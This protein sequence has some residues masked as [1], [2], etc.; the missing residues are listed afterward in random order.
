MNEDKATRYHRLKRRSSVAGV[1]SG[2]AA[3]AAFWLSGG[4]AWLR[5]AAETAVHALS[6]PGGVERSAVVGV[7]VLALCVGAELLAF[8]LAAYRG[9]VL[10]RR[11]GLSPQPFARWCAD[12]VKASLLGTVLAVAAALVGYA[13][14]DRSPR[15]W[16]AFTA[17]VFSAASV[18]IA[19]AAPVLLFPLFF[20]FRPLE[21]EQLV[22]RLIRLASKVGAPVLG[23]YEWSLG[24]RSRT[25]NAALVGIGGTRRILVSDTLLAAYSDDE[26]EVI[27]AH[28]LA[29][30]V[31]GDLWKALAVDAAL[32]LGALGFVHVMLQ[33]VP[34][35]GGV[36]GAA[37]VAGLPVVLLAAAA[38]SMV[39]LPAVNGLSRAHERQADRFAL[40]LTRNP[41]AFISAMKRLGAQNLAD[42]EPSPLVEWL[43]HSHPPLPR[44]L[45]AARA[46]QASAFHVSAR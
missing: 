28:E 36:R 9:F 11:Y 21:R 23:V 45:A 18:A 22:Q 17:L 8:P 15:W 14:M 33:V 37:D 16:W 10:E 32:L 5:T 46:W 34:S 29:H 2:L 20:K 41:D 1:A 31:H 30:H 7:Y 26:I 19:F 13:A 38:W 24:E 25:A 6:L 35:L 3:L 43:F 4:S 39:T 12:H 42:E 40:D 27:L 44:R